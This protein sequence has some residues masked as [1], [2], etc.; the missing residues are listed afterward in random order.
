MPFKRVLTMLVMLALLAAGFAV[1]ASA[2]DSGD[3][4]VIPMK[5]WQCLLCD[6][7]F[8]TF[9][10]DLLEAFPG[11][12]CLKD[13][14]FQQSNFMYFHDKSRPIEKCTKFKDG[15]H[16]FAY[17]E[18]TNVSPKW[19]C[20]HRKEIIVLKDGNSNTVKI[21]KI[22]CA[23]CGIVR[24]CFNGDDLDQYDFL[25]IKVQAPL[26]T[27]DN[28][29]SFPPC[30]KWYISDGKNNRIPIKH[31]L[32]SQISTFTPSSAY[33]IAEHIGYIIFSD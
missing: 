33:N 2:K 17:K 7:S 8:W 25:E 9:S 27:M 14:A 31:H 28:N 6:K 15:G 20:E 21:D 3:E 13:G 19:L 1:P 5:R 10:S 23:L 18:Y 22:Q 11:R 4:K 12:S 29:A 16:I 32:F 24:Y 30:N 26:W